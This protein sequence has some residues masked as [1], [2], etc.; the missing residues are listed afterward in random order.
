MNR[1]AE[2]IAH[3]RTEIEPLIG[4]TTEW[5]E[6]FRQVLSFRSFRRSLTADSFG[7]I[8][9]VK[10]ASPSAG[11]I[12]EDVNPV[13]VALAYDEA[14][15]NC[16]SVLTDQK[17]FHGHLSDLAAIR[18]TVNRPLLRKDFIV[19]EVQIYQAALAGADA[20]LLI[21]AALTD[22]ELDHFLSVSDGCGI[23]AL[24]EVHNEPELSRALSAGATF[25]GINNRNLTTFRVDLRTTEALAPLIPK[26]RVVISES[27]IKSVEDIRRVA[28]A[29]VHG[30]LIGESLMRAAN[31]QAVLKSFRAAAVQTQKLNQALRLETM[32]YRR[33]L[34]ELE[35]NPEPKT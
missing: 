18:K 19:H 35:H 3:K 13:K 8:A 23:D 28:A 12:S 33:T 25:I 9:E 11:V 22:K 10:K 1:L 21:V 17:Y 24:V 31:P 20:I 26:D 16:I 2:I 7:I 27:G 29:G 34:Q 32:D 4:H 15:A 14:G 30:A 5:R 6:K